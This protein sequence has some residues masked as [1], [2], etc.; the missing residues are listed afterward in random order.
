[1]GHA[2]GEIKMASYY[3]IAM[4]A[5][6]SSCVATAGEL[7]NIG[8]RLNIFFWVYFSS[9]SSVWKILGNVMLMQ[10]VFMFF[11]EIKYLTTDY[12]VCLPVL[13]FTRLVLD[14]LM[15]VM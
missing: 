8:C 6:L 4:F 9:A 7:Y 10:N 12:I 13:H 11:E 14:I 5:L 3:V 2:S 1:M 15:L